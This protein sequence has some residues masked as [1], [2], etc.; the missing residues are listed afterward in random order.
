MSLATSSKLSKIVLL[1]GNV[2]KKFKSFYHSWCQQIWNLCPLNETNTTE[3]KKLMPYFLLIFAQKYCIAKYLLFYILLFLYLILR[4][5]LLLWL[6][7]I[8]ELA[9]EVIMLFI[10]TVNYFLLRSS[11]SFT[12]FCYC[13]GFFFFSFWYLCTAS[14]SLCIIFVFNCFHCLICRFSL[15]FSL[16][17]LFRFCHR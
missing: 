10:T 9:L 11:L 7:I 3:R 17:S 5:L 4:E 13:H 1:N 14:S 6:T 15:V 8:N 12:D 2:Y 16:K